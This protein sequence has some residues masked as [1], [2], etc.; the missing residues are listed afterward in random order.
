[1]DPDQA[2]VAG[3]STSYPK[4]AMSF[5]NAAFAEPE[6]MNVRFD[7]VLGILRK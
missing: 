5:M 4:D 2:A 1:M 3:K 7:A 6:K